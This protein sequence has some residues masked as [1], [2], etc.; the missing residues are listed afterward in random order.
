MG[1]SSSKSGPEES[2]EENASNPT[3]AGLPTGSGVVQAP[4]TSLHTRGFGASAGKVLFPRA[5]RAACR[6]SRGKPR[7]DSTRADRSQAT[8]A[9][10]PYVPVFGLGHP[11]HRSCGRDDEVVGASLSVR[12]CRTFTQASPVCPRARSFIRTA[13]FLAQSF[14][15]GWGDA[16]PS[17]SAEG[18]RPCQPNKRHRSW[19]TPSGRP[20]RKCKG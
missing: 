8:G 6:G 17:R 16:M 2:C 18:D 15:S 4:P 13:D 11:F 1:N 5:I 12:T 19:S 7:R 3:T 14:I 9:G 10:I 20:P